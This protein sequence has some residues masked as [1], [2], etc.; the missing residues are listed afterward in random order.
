MERCKSILSSRVLPRG[1]VVS[2]LFE[3]FTLHS[4]LLQNTCLFAWA[5]DFLQPHGAQDR[6]YLVNISQE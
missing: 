6:N 5:F 3:K 4:Q 2:I 1:F